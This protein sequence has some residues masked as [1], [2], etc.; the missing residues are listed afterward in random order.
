MKQFYSKYSKH[1]LVLGLLLLPF[2]AYEGE[3]LPANNDIE[4]W[5][6]QDSQIHID[7]EWFKDQFGAEEVILIGIPKTV[8]DDRL[9][10]ALAGR[11]QQLPGVRQVWTPR[12]FGEVM[13]DLGVPSDVIDTRLTGLTLSHDHQMVG[14]VALL[15]PTGLANRSKT[16]KN[17]RQVLNY[18]QLPEEQILLTGAPVVVAELNHLGGVEQNR[19]F[20]VITQIISFVLLYASLRNVK[21]AGAILLITIFAI[22]LT[23]ATIKWTG[24]EMNFILA[25]LPVMVM[26]FTLAIAVHVVHYYQTLLGEPDAFGTALA[27]AWKPVALATLT[28]VIGLI[29][30]AV[31][32]IVPIQQFGIAGSI[33]A[34]AAMVAGLGFTPALLVVWPEA[35][36]P[37]QEKRDDWGSNWAH[38]LIRNSRLITAICLVSLCVASVGVIW[39]KPRIDPLDF[40]P[41][42]SKVVSDLLQCERELTNVES[43][44]VVVDFGT[45]DLSFVQKLNR[46]RE[47]ESRIV[48]H[49]AV[50]HTMSLAS[51]FPQ[52]MP[53][54]AMEA[55]RL[56]ARAQSSDHR[57]DYLSAGERYWRISAR[58][59]GDT[60]HDK[61]IAFNELSKM[62]ADEPVRLTG[63]APLLGQAQQEIFRGFWESFASAFVVIGLVMAC[64]VRSVK[65]AF[66]AMLPNMGPIFFVFGILGWIGMTIDIGMMMTASIALGIAVDGTFHFLVIYK[67]QRK[68]K[69]CPERSAY[70]ALM[71]TGA[72][73]FQ[74]A[75]IASCGMLALTGS[76]FSP[77]V[78]FGWLMAVLLMVAVVGDLV[79]LP[80]LLCQLP[81]D[82]PQSPV[83]PALPA[84]PPRQNTKSRAA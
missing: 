19:I 64:S 12:R 66:L 16:V 45:E 24:G 43:I 3:R 30:L 57:G 60:P 75:L 34:I 53:S 8:A 4:T 79:F 73:I 35:V 48:S 78:R 76:S 26:V 51:F 84:E 23:Q 1:L 39:L 25:A 31:S 38:A 6:P 11:L 36:Q 29:S 62:L 54:R 59:A 22:E 2:L 5:L 18:C 63:I 9:V 71:H 56:F 21:L 69:V 42:H 20:F 40:L 70:E 65:I 77:T 82:K 37:I 58:V 17:V 13:S 61:E 55:A 72:P 32:K 14:I 49:P 46:V 28:T 52:E 10:E 83:T 81:G 33:G 41:Q 44:E 47:I 27:R 67:Q 74:A 50:R 68:Q 80:A 15:S 7:Y